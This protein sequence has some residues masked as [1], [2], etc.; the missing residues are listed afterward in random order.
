MRE[1]NFIRTGKLDWIERD[2]P[3]LTSAHRLSQ[4]ATA[5]RVAVMDGGRI[6]EIGNHA[7]LV[8]AGGQYAMLWRAWNGA[9]L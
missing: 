1:L 6:V 2:E 3:V 8:A 4:A 5:D 9:A 7:E